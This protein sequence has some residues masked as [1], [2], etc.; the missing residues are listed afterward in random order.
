MKYRHL[1]AFLFI[2]LIG[3]Y[4]LGYY[5]GYRQGNIAVQNS[6]TALFN[7]QKE[8]RELREKRL[9]KAPVPMF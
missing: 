3:G 7:C 9:D 8:L 1:L 6:N 4:G 5:Y 2:G